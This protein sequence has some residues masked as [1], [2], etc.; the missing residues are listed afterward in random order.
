MVE[1]FLTTKMIERGEPA[2]SDYLQTGQSDFSNIWKEA[3]TDLLTD[4]IDSN[5]NVRQ[6]C[7][8][9]SLQSSVTKTAA[10]TGAISSEDFAQRMR[11]VI[12]VSVVTGDAIFTLQGTDDG[13][14]Y[15]DIT[16]VADSG[17]SST[18]VTIST[19]AVGDSS[20]SYLITKLYKKYR[21]KLI[22]ITTTVTYTS[23]MIEEIYTSLHRDKARA[24]VYE[25]L[26]ST[27]SDVWQGKF[28]GY[29]ERYNSR[30]STGKF[31]IDIS[32]DE[33]ISEGEGEVHIQNVRFVK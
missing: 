26:K 29:I 28:D 21:L 15:S 13:S 3:F 31:V 22:S 12:P 9:F 32:D 33:N 25:S 20:N 5:L 16:L 6:L 23:Y 8:Q 1:S 18:T 24:N 11:L 2:I 17:T 10:F 30:M 19:A 4:L 7:K 14:T 27:E